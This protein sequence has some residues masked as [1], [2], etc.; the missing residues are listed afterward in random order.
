M[1]ILSIDFYINKTFQLTII[2]FELVP[3]PKTKIDAS[4]FFE[5]VP[6]QGGLPA[7]GDRNAQATSVTVSNSIVDCILIE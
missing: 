1:N 6:K 3:D 5:I 7:G 2:R 4:K